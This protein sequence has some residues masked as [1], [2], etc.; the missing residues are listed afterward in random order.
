MQ[1]LDG[2]PAQID[3][4]GLEEEGLGI[5]VAQFLL[6]DTGQLEVVVRTQALIRKKE[7]FHSLTGLVRRRTGRVWQ[8]RRG[9]DTRAVQPGCVGPAVGIVVPTGGDHQPASLFHILTQ[10]RNLRFRVGYTRDDHEPGVLQ[11]ALVQLVEPDV[12][13]LHQLPWRILATGHRR[14]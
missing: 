4:D 9:Q 14:Q 8:Q 1:R 7:G 10:Q 12:T 2:F 5:Q 13:S 6:A 3:L 11:Y